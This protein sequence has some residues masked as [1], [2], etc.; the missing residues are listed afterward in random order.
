MGILNAPEGIRYYIMY[1]EAQ[2]SV[3]VVSQLEQMKQV[4]NYLAILHNLADDFQSKHTGLSWDLD[5]LID[6]G[7]QQL[8]RFIPSDLTSSLSS[9]EHKAEELITQ[10]YHLIPEKT[11]EYWGIIHGGYTPK[12]IRISGDRV[13]A[14]DFEYCGYGYRI[15][16]MV[17][18]LNQTNLMDPKNRAFN[19][20]LRGYQ[21]NR[22]L[23]NQEI[24][25]IPLLSRLALI[26][27]MTVSV[28]MR[29]LV[30]VL[31]FER[32]LRDDLKILEKIL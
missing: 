13:L 18:M 21:E 14:F 11:K 25:A 9:I 15:F 32:K 19:A 29:N 22:A 20:F 28:G 8:K 2:G 17:F 1:T 31:W 16:D 4:G 10:F 27:Q 12:N 5:L 24:L 3:P 6:H 26:S 7:I 23:S 30:G